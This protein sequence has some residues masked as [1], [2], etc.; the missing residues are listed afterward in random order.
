MSA[1]EGQY[2][3]RAKSWGAAAA[4]IGQARLVGTS[5]AGGDHTYLFTPVVFTHS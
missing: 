4:E 2:E 3:R 5:E 1:E